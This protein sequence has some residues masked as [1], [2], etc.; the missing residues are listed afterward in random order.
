MSLMKSCADLARTGYPLEFGT[1]EDAGRK[2]KRVG[3]ADHLE[4]FG[5]LLGNGAV[6]SRA[7]KT[8]T[9]W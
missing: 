7:E 3:S 2:M 8:E 9:G 5:I 4:R 6:R 1:K